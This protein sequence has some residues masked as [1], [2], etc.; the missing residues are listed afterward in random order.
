MKLYKVGSMKT[1]NEKL[2][3]KIS[4]ICSLGVQEIDTDKI[5]HEGISC[6]INCYSYEQN[7]LRTSNYVSYTPCNLESDKIYL[8]LQYDDISDEDVFFGKREVFYKF[9]R[10]RTVN[11]S[12]CIPI[13]K[14]TKKYVKELMPTMQIEVDKFILEC[15][16]NKK[17]MTK[18]IYIKEESNG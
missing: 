13:Q 8:D 1:L 4:K 7:R 5:Q 9:N 16:Q 10:S 3:N 17:F 2:A 15:K 14:F 11:L 6:G 12:L 18:R